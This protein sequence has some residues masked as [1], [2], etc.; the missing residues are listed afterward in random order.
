MFVLALE[1]STT[2]AKAMYYNTETESYELSTRPYTGNYD[3]P[4]KHRPDNVYNQM[5]DTGRDLLRGRKV[6]I[7]ALSGTWHSV[8][9]FNKDISPAT[10]MYLWSNV[11]P[12]KICAKL[13]QDR[14]YVHD[15]YNRTGCMVNAIYGVF[16]LM[17]LR[18][19]L[20]LKDTFHT[21]ILS[22]TLKIN[23][24]VARL[25]IALHKKLL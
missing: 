21:A 3:D 9:L 22:F 6:D 5:L 14:K 17:M 12:T 24:I 18:Q 7:I 8:G 20:D 10:P 13:R 2:S 4:S 19:N 23:I 15:F 1:A 11:E 25:V 16:K